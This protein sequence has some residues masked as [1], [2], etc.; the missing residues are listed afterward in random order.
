M[1]CASCLNRIGFTSTQRR[2]AHGMTFACEGYTVRP[3]RASLEWR[4]ARY[5]AANPCGIS[6]RWRELSGAQASWRRRT[7]SI[8]PS[9]Q[10]VRCPCRQRAAGFVS[11][12]KSVDVLAK[13]SSVAWP[14]KSERFGCD[15]R[16]NRDAL[17]EVFGEL[18]LCPL[19]NARL[20]CDAMCN[21]QHVALR[22][23]VPG[24]FTLSPTKM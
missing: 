19:R 17:R 23:Q 10:P 5:G 8:R 14:R 13:R 4:V 21:T 24:T 1:P 20:D 16:Q 9:A 3:H 15:K 18:H 2:H 6:R 22:G 7:Q 11:R 12:R